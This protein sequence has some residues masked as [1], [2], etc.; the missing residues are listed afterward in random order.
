MLTEK[1]GP[2][3][4]FHQKCSLKFEI[5]ISLEITHIFNYISLYRVCQGSHQ[6]VFFIG[7]NFA[8]LVRLSRL[9]WCKNSYHTLN[10][11]F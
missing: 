1:S 4:I 8:S 2:K 11:K 7:L 5:K 6:G 3:I 9:F 10:V